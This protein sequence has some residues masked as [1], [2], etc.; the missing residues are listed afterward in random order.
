VR[1]GDRGPAC[2]IRAHFIKGKKCGRPPV[3]GAVMS[4]GVVMLKI[5][6]INPVEVL[7]R[8]SSKSCEPRAGSLG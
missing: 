6:T 8:L 7:N 1:T 3:A 5:I 4:L 2:Q